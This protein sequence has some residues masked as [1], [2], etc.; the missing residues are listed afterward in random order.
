MSSENRINDVTQQLWT[1]I[2]QLVGDI[3]NPTGEAS[4][5]MGQISQLLT[6]TI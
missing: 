1:D 3:C 5:F 6:A 2:G 4:Q